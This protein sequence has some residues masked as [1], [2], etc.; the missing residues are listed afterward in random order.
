MAQEGNFA[1]VTNLE[2]LDGYI[3]E[4]P[5]GKQ[6]RLS[7]IIVLP[8][9]GFTLNNV[10]KNVQSL[11]L[12]P[13]LQRI[14]KFRRDQSDENEVEVVMPKFTTSTDFNFK[15]LLTT[16]GWLCLRSEG[17]T[18]F[19]LVFYRWAYGIYLMKPNRTSVVWP[20]ACIQNFVYT[21]PKSLW[22]NREPPPQ[23]SHL[24]CWA[25]SQHLRNSIWIDPSNIWLWRSR[26]IC[27]FSRVKLG[28]HCLSD[29]LMFSL[30]S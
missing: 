11:G 8:K 9:R 7:M 17:W 15:H 1:Y 5:Y 30:M 12:A 21:P 13:I 22:T 26:P 3:L 16:V 23:Q 18:K 10:A 29:E 2:G 14:E 24:L 4:L 19:D 6:D 20:M 25:T 28:N 27:Y